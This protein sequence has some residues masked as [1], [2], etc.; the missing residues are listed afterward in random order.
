MIATDTRGRL[1]VRPSEG[2]PL[3]LGHGELDGGPRDDR[4]AWVALEHGRAWLEL[5]GGRPVDGSHK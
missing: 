3:L 1:V 4:D 2:V 5:W